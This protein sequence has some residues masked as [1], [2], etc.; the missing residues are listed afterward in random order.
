MGVRVGPVG[1]LSVVECNQGVCPEGQPGGGILPTAFTTKGAHTPMHVTRE[2]D[3][4][5]WRGQGGVEGD[6]GVGR[7]LSLL[8]CHTKKEKQRFCPQ[9][10]CS[11]TRRLED[12]P[13]CWR[14]SSR[15]KV[16]VCHWPMRAVEQKPTKHDESI[17]P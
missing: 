10:D 3:R 2:G 14:G 13:K 11:V 17:I 16:Y 9:G 12:Q 15:G 5:G 6:R 1:G 7:C 8:L 4:V